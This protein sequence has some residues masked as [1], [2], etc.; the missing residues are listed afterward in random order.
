MVAYY[1]LT[2]VSRAFSSMPGLASGIALQIRN[3]EIKKFLIQ[4]V[5]ML[6]FLMLS[7]FAHK[8]AYYTVAASLLRSSFSCAAVSSSTAGRM[9]ARWRRSSCH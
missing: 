6:G 9:R 4:P 8:L 1:L 5:D 2:M 7:R 3:G